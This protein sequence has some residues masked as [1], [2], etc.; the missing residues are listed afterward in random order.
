MENKN[1]PTAKQANTGPS[2]CHI[3]SFMFA[4]SITA[5]M[6]IELHERMYEPPL[7]TAVRNLDHDSVVRE[8]MNGIDPNEKYYG[9]TVLHKL[10][11]MHGDLVE[12]DKRFDLVMNA[13][14]DHGARFDNDYFFGYVLQYQD[15]W[16]RLTRLLKCGDVNRVDSNGN[17]LLYYVIVNEKYDLAKILIENSAN[18]GTDEALVNSRLMIDNGIERD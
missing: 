15:D 5:F 13:L 1:E 8:L 6:A 11:I 14:V 9:M 12:V 4:F 10:F 17:T 2:S 7:F 18:G 16:Q 3:I